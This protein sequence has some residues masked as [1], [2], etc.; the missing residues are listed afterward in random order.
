MVLWRPADIATVPPGPAST[1]AGTTGWTHNGGP[2]AAVSVRVDRLPATIERTPGWNPYWPRSVQPPA[3]APALTSAPIRDTVML[4]MPYSPD[5][6]G[7][8]PLIDPA[9]LPLFAYGE[10]SINGDSG[11]GTYHWVR[12]NVDLLET[13]DAGGNRAIALDQNSLGPMGQRAAFAQPDELVIVD[14]ASFGGR[15][16]GAVHRI[17]V[18]GLNEE[19]TWLT[20]GRYVLVSSATKTW[21]VNVD[22][23]SVVPAA[24]VGWDGD[25]VGRR[26]QR[27]DHPGPSRAR[28]VCA[29][30]L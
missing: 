15:T 10:G 21:L 20:D 23:A 25:C 28:G 11:D 24:A 13:R 5:P 29:A 4:F 9:P 30:H 27:A 14:L 2:T 26:R 17:P 3:N 1:G 12:V 19:V 6:D 18:P 16:A 22:T 7:S 8:E